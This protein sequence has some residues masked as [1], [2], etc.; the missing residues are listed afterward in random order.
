MQNRKYFPCERNHYY[1]GKLL[2]AKDF[3]AEQAYFNDKR[4]LRSRLENGVGVAAGLGVIM[5]D[6]TSVIVQSGCAYDGAG[7]EIIVPETKVVKLSA[8]DGYSQLMSGCAYLGI[9]YDEQPTEEVYGAMS[10]QPDGTCFNKIGEGYRLT[11]L[12]ESMVA[13]VDAPTDPFLTRTCLYG[14]NEVQLI[15]TTP[16]FVTRGSQLSVCV[17]LVRVGSGGSEYSFRYQLD[18]PSFANEQGTQQT[19]ITQGHIRLALGERKAWHFTYQPEEHIWGGNSSA[20]FAISGLKVQKND[21]VFASNDTTAVLLQPVQQ[22]MAELCIADWYQKAMDKNLAESY[23][24]RIWIAKINLIRQ[25]SNIMVERI[26][27]VPFAQYSYNPQQMM[28]LH[29]L[30]PFYPTGASAA[31][32]G[33]SAPL[34][35]AQGAPAALAPA[36]PQTSASG[37]FELTF[38]LGHNIKEPIFSEEIMHGLGKEP[39]YVDVAVEYIRMDAQ[40][41]DVSEFVLGDAQIFETANSKNAK[42]FYNLSTAVKVLPERGTFV[43]GVKLGEATDLI[44]LRIRWFAFKMGAAKKQAQNNIGGKKYIQIS[45]DTIVLAPKGTTHITPVFTGMPSEACVYRM[46]DAEGGT[47]DNNGVYTAPAKEGV[48]EIHVEAVSDASVYTHAFVI[49]SQKTKE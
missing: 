14:D 47:I 33:A 5:A 41:G 21:E 39:V 7:R 42:H 1:F 17:E 45:P 49:V 20:R 25:N 46:I 40:K 3:E 4:R 36:P 19:D 35:G 13:K 34:Q 16:K 38:G 31:Q 28:L 18:T 6:D 29:Q 37:V 23:D 48:Y 12:D 15:Q 44:R 9:V 2:T 32:S 22:T 43:V 10:N 26:A 27:P 24:Q 30:A 11:L 8:I